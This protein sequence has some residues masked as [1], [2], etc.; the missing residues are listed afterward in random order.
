MVEVMLF[1]GCLYAGYRIFRKPG[2]NFFYK[3]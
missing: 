3:D 2:E 1:F